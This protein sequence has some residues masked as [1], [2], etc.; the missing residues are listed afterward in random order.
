MKKYIG[1]ELENFSIATLWRKYTLSKVSDYYRDKKVLEIGPGVG[2]FSELIAKKCKSLTM[3]EP[4][5]EFCSILKKKLKNNKKIIKII[6]GRS[7]NVRG[8]F[9]TI[10][11]FQVLEHIKQDNKEI[12][13]NLNLLNENG[14]MLICVPSF[15]SLYSS[16]DRAIG[17]FKRYEKKDFDNFKLGNS[18]IIKMF[19]LDSCGYLVY[20]FF[21]LFLN[22][23]EPKKFMIFIW[24]KFFI[25]ISFLLD[26]FLRY[27]IGKNLIVVIQK[28]SY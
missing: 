11:H 8:K 4:D 19:Y 25:P 14:Y 22:S 3:V 17:H 23:S 28:K 2:S 18:R 7:D 13:K 20:S 16:F 26:F 10:V 9:D 15:M 6:N 12:T 5:Y 27:S 24:D 21:K 1:K